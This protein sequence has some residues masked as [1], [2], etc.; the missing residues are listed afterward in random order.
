MKV[1][2]LVQILWRYSEM[3]DPTDA[4]LLF[5]KLNAVTG[6]EPRMAASILILRDT[7]E[8]L[9]VLMVVR[10]KQIEFASG[11][12]VYPGGRRMETDSPAHMADRLTGLQG[13]DEMEASL[14]VA[15]IREAYE[16]VGLLPAAQSAAEPARDRHIQTIDVYRSAVDKGTADFATVLREAHITLD[17]S[18]LTRF[19]HII[20][21]KITPKRFNTHF[22]AVRASDGQTPR[23][24]GSEI[25]E[26]VWIRPEQALA[27][28][29]RGERE[30]MFPTRMVL[31]RLAGFETVDA[32][33][34]GAR[35]EPPLPVQ[36]Q[37]ELSDGI[38]GLRTAAVPGFPSTWETLDGVSGKRKDPSPTG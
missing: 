22:F 14:R 19:A 38:V 4:E 32:A 16:E 23:A 11:A 34:A 8:G 20:A 5:A 25:I 6:P 28:A 29:A 17:L 26:T 37:L 24:D 2:D 33:I 18:L 13:L 36:P 27:L 15:A 30:V 7:P 3:S 9:E 12:M 35:R 10:S 21:P 1:L 31:W